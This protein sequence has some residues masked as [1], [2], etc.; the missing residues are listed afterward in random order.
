MITKDKNDIIIRELK[1]EDARR[2]SYLIRKTVTEVNSQDYPPAV[3]RFM[4][5]N[6]SPTRIVEKVSNRL[7]YVAIHRSHLVGT[8][9]LEENHISSLFVN[10]TCQHRGIGTK[11]MMPVESIARKT[12]YTTVNLG[13]SLT[14][15]EFYKKLGYTTM[16]TEQSDKFGTYIVMEK[17]L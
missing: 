16:R 13:S 9:S 6:Y 10:P 2:V 7:T 8:V 3:I 1:C 14:A 5:H 4:I 17:N 12:G 15:Y 11:L